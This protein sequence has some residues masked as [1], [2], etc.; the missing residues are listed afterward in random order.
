MPG[1]KGDEF[2]V[3]FKKKYP[4]TITIML[5]GQADEKAVERAFQEGGLYAC[6]KKPWSKEELI[7]TIQKAIQEI[8]L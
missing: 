3:Q 6:I 1:Q 5:T 2:L 8:Q 7:V 4:K